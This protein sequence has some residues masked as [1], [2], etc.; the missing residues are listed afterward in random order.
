MLQCHSSS[1]P[2]Y[3]LLNPLS[4]ISVSLLSSENILRAAASGQ[5]RGNTTLQPYQHLIH[6]PVKHHPGPFQALLCNK[7][8]ALRSRGLDDCNSVSD[9]TCEPAWRPYERPA[10][11]LLCPG[12]V[13]GTVGDVD[14]RPSWSPRASDSVATLIC[15]ARRFLDTDC[16]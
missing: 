8:V 15:H 14:T 1:I 10:I 3:P 13:D 16:T 6:P 4:T 5:E 2:K 11:S 9:H 7:E 12:Y